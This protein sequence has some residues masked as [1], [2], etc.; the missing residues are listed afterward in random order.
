VYASVLFVRA[1]CGAGSGQRRL[2]NVRVPCTALAAEMRRKTAAHR[3]G[4]SSWLSGGSQCSQ[5]PGRSAARFRQIFPGL[6]MKVSEP[7]WGD[8]SGSCAGRINVEKPGY[9]RLTVPELLG[10]RL[11]GADKALASVPRFPDPEGRRPVCRHGR[12]ENRHLF[13]NWLFS[14]EAKINAMK[15]LH[16]ATLCG[17]WGYERRRLRQVRKCGEQESSVNCL[18]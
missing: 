12:G 13:P 5:R 2:K 1:L 14:I 17:G 3:R 16:N 11:S 4:F 9:G 18:F 8:C 7:S 15:G 6:S 10:F